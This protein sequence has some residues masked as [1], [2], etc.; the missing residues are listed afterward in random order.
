[1]RIHP[2]VKRGVYCLRCYAPLAETNAR[3]IDC[4][5]CRATNLR[6]DRYRYWTRARLPRIVEGFCKLLAIGI[7]LVV[8]VLAMQSS[9]GGSGQ[10]YVLAL[11]ILLGFILWETSRAITHKQLTLDP[12]FFWYGGALTCGLLG[13]LDFVLSQTFIGLDSTSSLVLGI[14]GITLSFA[15]AA[16]RHWRRVWIGWKIDRRTREL[17]LTDD[18]LF[19]SPTRPLEDV[20]A[21]NARGR[22]GRRSQ[23]AASGPA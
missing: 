18:P 1:M 4:I 5:A 8:A 13:L 6:S 15:F 19:N 16:L 7:T 11:P 10:G 12:G 21:E 2:R 14:G 17:Q 22:R 3:A 9:G 20:R 23:S